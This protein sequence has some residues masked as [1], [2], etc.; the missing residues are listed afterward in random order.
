MI[1][2]S[3]ACSLQDEAAESARRCCELQMVRRG[4]GRDES[5]MR[6]KISRVRR[7]RRYPGA[8]AAA[9]R[10]RDRRARTVVGAPGE[11]LVRDRFAPGNAGAFVRAVLDAQQNGGIELVEAGSGGRKQ[12]HE[13][14]V[15]GGTGCGF[16][17]SAGGHGARHKVRFMRAGDAV[18]GVVNR[19]VKNGESP[20]R[21]GRW[22]FAGTNGVQRG[23]IPVGDDVCSRHDR[24]EQHRQGCLDRKRVYFHKD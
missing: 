4:K 7:G 19:A 20:R 14:F 11:D 9:R 6:Q 12:S 5:P 8:G 22:R 16:P 1:I 10:L 18:D 13:R 3:R 2:P 15:R 24:G 21:D 17:G 23:V